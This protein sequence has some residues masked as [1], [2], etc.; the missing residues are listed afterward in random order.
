MQNTSRKKKDCANNSYS[1]SVRELIIN[2]LKEI[3]QKAC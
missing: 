2:L 3:Q 1:T